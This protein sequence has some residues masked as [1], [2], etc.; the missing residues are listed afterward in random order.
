MEE[1][2]HVDLESANATFIQSSENENFLQA[3]EISNVVH[4][5]DAQPDSDVEKT[6]PS[7]SENIEKSSTVLPAKHGFFSSALS[8]KRKLVVIKLT[9]S[10]LLMA[11][12]IMGFLSIYWGSFYKRIEHLQR[13][14]LW[15]VNLDNYSGSTI[16]PQFISVAKEFVKNMNTIQVEV[17]DVSVFGKDYS[18]YVDYVTE[19]NTWGVF[20][21]RE[22]ATGILNEA[23]ANPSSTAASTYNGSLAIQFLFAQARDEVAYGYINPWVFQLNDVFTSAYLQTTLKNAAANYSISNILQSA[24]GLL[25][26]PAK[27][28]Q[29]DLRPFD[30][31]V[32][33]ATTQVGLIYLIIVS[34]F[35]FNFFQPVHMIIAQDLKI[36]H[37]VLYRIAA[38]WI[39]YFFLSLFFSLISLAFQIDFTA[40][41][42][43]GGFVVYW[44][45][46]FIGMLAVGGTCE[47]MA[48]I[49]FAIYPPLVGLCLICVVITN[50]SVAFY[51]IP[52]Q[53]KFY[54]YGYAF[55]IKN[56][57]DA[58]KTVIFNTKNTMGRNVGVVIVWIVLD[59]IGLPICLW[60]FGRQMRKK[61]AAATIF[62]DKKR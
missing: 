62:A 13:V 47:N 23:L 6:S 1:N 11:V 9:Q 41:Y 17:K 38:S 20:F 49:A 34:F 55:P 51:S 25:S 45:L 12:F 31:P 40:K 43:N 29:V 15:I 10:V 59:I 30:I 35:Q 60:F 3:T 28:A 48:L 26:A 52:L 5:Y 7:S 58:F 2:R 8:S 46:N 33:T 54:R 56:L 61:Q 27:I 24:P 14:H 19:E 57:S 53:A 32:A 42:G 4:S 37:H 50:V 39:A 18:R 21:I 44:M 36:H 16:G 22:N